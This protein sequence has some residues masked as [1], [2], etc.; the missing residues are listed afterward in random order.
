MKISGGVSIIG[1]LDDWFVSKLQGLEYKPE[2][3][4]YVAGVLKTLAHPSSNDAFEQRSIVLAYADARLSGDFIK[5][6]RIGDYVLWAETIIPESIALDREVVVTIGKLSYYTCYRLTQRSWPVYV[7][8]AEQ[9]PAISA[10]AR[11]RLI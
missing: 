4:A 3:I 2:T 7:E 10:A 5:F 6:Q 1:G 8:L 11:K 9:L